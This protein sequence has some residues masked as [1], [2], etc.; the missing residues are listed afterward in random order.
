MASLTWWTWVLSKLL[1]LVIDREAWR[2][3]VHGVTKSRTWLS[4]WTELNWL[5][6]GEEARDRK[7]W[8]CTCLLSTH[9]APGPWFVPGAGGWKMKGNLPL[10]SGNR[11]PN[12]SDTTFDRQ[13]KTRVERLSSL[14]PEVPSWKQELGAWGRGLC[15]DFVDH[16]HTPASTALTSSNLKVTMG[17]APITH[18]LPALRQL[19]STFPAC[20]G[21]FFHTQ[22]GQLIFLLRFLTNIFWR[23]AQ[24]TWKLSFVTS[25]IRFFLSVLETNHNTPSPACV[26]SAVMS[27]SRQPEC[28]I[29][30]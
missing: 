27:H 20:R 5:N 21:N 29:N 9:C 14:A 10:T 18:E 4:N 2:A 1:E 19:E 12:Q 26:L 24:V 30:K 25:S 13:P 6:S 17:V 28:E 8:F 23:A 3:V 16:S 22:I 7:A 15:T 11:T